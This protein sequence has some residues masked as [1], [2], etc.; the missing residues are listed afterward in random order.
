MKKTKDKKKE[1]KEI[2]LK[3]PK[4]IQPE[5]LCTISV[6]CLKVSLDGQI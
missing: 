4:K 1:I 3:K 2:S 6:C 5:Q